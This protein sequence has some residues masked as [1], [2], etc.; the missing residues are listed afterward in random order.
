MN[1]KIELNLNE[2]PQ[3]K[4]SNYRHFHDGER[5]VTRQCQ[6]H[7]LLMMFDGVLTF[8]ENGQEVSLSAGDWYVQRP[9][10]H[11]FS[12]QPCVNPS[13]YYIH[14]MGDT[15]AP[16]PHSMPLYGQMNVPVME[17][18]VSKLH[19]TTLDPRASRTKIHYAFYDLLLALSSA[20]DLDAESAVAHQVFSRLQQHVSKSFSMEELSRQF[21]YHPDHI[22]RI[23]KKTYGITPCQFANHLRLD[24]AQTLLSTSNR[25]IQQIAFDCGWS[26]PSLFYRAFV[27]AYKLSPQ[28]YRMRHRQ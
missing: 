4:S 27:K 2:L 18:H 12:R 28:Q 26:A 16:G 23:F 3:Y 9:G 11:T 1:H 13:Y 22:T 6:A 10:S 17:K 19:Q 8:T 15:A 21:G 20:E 24:R 25:S 7:V 5:H 14:F